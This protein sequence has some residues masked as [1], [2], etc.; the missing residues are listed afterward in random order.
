MKIHVA[1]MSEETIEG[2]KHVVVSDNHINFMDI[3]DNECSEILANDVLDSFFSDKTEDCL[4]SLVNKLRLGGK[5]IVGGKRVDRNER[6]IAS[7]AKYKLHAT[8]KRPNADSAISW[9]KSFKHSDIW[10]SF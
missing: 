8:A 4:V 1:K 5:L 2:Y 6:C 9:P 10:D 3:S 7:I